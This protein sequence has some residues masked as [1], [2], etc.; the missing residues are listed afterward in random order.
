M[1]L[2]DEFVRT[3][4]MKLSNSLHDPHYQ[5]YIEEVKSH[6]LN[7]IEEAQEKGKGEGE[8]LKELKVEFMAPE[9]LAEEFAQEGGSKGGS[10]QSLLFISSIIIALALPVFFKQLGTIPL[11]MILFIYSFIVLIK[12]DLLFF[13]VSRQNIHKLKKQKKEVIKK[14]S[15]LGS[16][17]LFL[18]GVIVLLN[19]H[20]D[21]NV[22]FL[23]ALLMNIPISIYIKKNIA[24]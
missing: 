5:N 23:I 10:K 19:N 3:Y 4:I 17:Y 13:A 14:L 22:L 20:F 9:Q 16:I 18:L 15:F 24:Y 12:K 11:A 6:I 8:I 21:L 7:Y 2:L 1:S